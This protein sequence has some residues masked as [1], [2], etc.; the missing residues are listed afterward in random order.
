M[1][2]PSPTHPG[3]RCIHLLRPFSYGSCGGSILHCGAL[4]NDI[5]EQARHVDILELAPWSEYLDPPA[6]LCPLATRECPLLARTRILTRVIRCTRRTR[7]TMQGTPLA[8][9]SS[10]PRDASGV[11][12]LSSGLLSRYPS[13]I[14][15]LGLMQRQ[16]RLRAIASRALPW[17]RGSVDARARDVGAEAYSYVYSH[18][19]WSPRVRTYPYPSASRP[20]LS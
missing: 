16:Y 19:P 3:N 4:A 13:V 7:H 14:L 15:S 5:F 10:C 1:H 6:C 18:H 17:H 2:Y 11:L 9:S 8:A 20:R 12:A